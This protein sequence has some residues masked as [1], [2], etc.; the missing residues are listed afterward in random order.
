MIDKI[1]IIE[2]KKHKLVIKIFGDKYTL[3]NLLID[4]LYRNEDVK[5]ASYNSEHPLERSVILLIE[6][7]TKNPREVLKEA[8]DK[9]V[10][11]LKHI[12]KALA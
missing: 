6:T 11:K 10:K 3:T 12:E 1:E 5:S 2:E 8:I 9:T 4:E 7:K